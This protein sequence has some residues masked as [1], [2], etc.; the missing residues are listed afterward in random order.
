MSYQITKKLGYAH[1]H[2]VALTLPVLWDRMISNEDALPILMDLSAKMRLGSEYMGS[3]LL[4]GLII[5]LGMEVTEMP[6]DATLD[7]LAASVNT[8][9]LGNHPEP[10]TTAELRDIYVQALSPVAA[11]EKERLAALWRKYAE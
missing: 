7:A 3:R 1:G 4:R 8:E 11:A 10:L 5:D 9:R 2:A 6:D